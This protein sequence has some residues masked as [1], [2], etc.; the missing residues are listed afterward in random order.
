MSKK[1]FLFFLKFRG[2]SA[3]ILTCPDPPRQKF[4]LVLTPLAS[5]GQDFCYKI[6]A[7]FSRNFRIW[8]CFKKVGMHILPGSRAGQEFPPSLRE[9]KKAGS[10][11]L[12]EILVLP[13]TPGGNTS[14]K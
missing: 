3:G 14:F 11:P 4:Y 12:A 6:S 5:A 7:E 8:L 13:S 10:L 9:A 1:F 2:N